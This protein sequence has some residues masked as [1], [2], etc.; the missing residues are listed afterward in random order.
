MIEIDETY[1]GGK[2]ENMVKVRCEV[3]FGW[4]V[5]GKSII[6][7]AK[8][9]STNRVSAAVVERT[10]MASLLSTKWNWSS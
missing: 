7:S 5:M 9:R 6:T 2:R 3:L 1:I 8:D 10:D 4:G